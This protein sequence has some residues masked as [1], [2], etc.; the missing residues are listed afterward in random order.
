MMK[1]CFALNLKDVFVYGIFLYAIK[2]HAFRAPLQAHVR[3]LPNTLHLNR[4]NGLFFPIGFWKSSRCNSVQKF[5]Y[6]K[7][8]YTQL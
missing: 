6:L 5:L 1:N 7:H 3:L 4:T 8:Y 2:R